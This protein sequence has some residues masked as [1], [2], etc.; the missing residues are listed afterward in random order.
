MSDQFSLF[1]RPGA[2]QVVIALSVIMFTL[3]VTGYGLLW[4]YVEQQQN[5]VGRTY[6]LS[7]VTD[8]NNKL[9]SQRENLA[10]DTF[11]KP[12]IV[13]KATIILFEPTGQTTTISR[14][15][16][17][18]VEQLP[19]WTS[20]SS[21]YGKIFYY[22]NG[23][24]S[25]QNL[26]A[27][28]RLYVR[29]YYYPFCYRFTNPVYLLPL[30]LVFCIFLLAMIYLRKRLNLWYQM[31]DYA[32]DLHLNTHKGYQP[33]ATTLYQHHPELLHLA[34]L[35]NRYAFKL[36]QSHQ[37]ITALRYHHQ[38]LVD[39]AP[40][41]LFM[42]NRK[43]RINYFN[44]HFSQIFQ[45]SFSDN[46]VY[47]L[48][49]FITGLD[50]AAQQ[51]LND[52]ETVHTYQ[53]IAVTNLQCNLY[54]QLKINPHYNRYGRL[55]GYSCGLED[56]TNYQEKLQQAWVEDK[57]TSDKISNFNKMWAV[58]GHELRTPLGGIVGM[59]GLLAD[60][61]SQFNR[62]QQDTID[63]LQHSSQTMM[64]LLNDM[65]NVAKFDVGKLQTNISSM[66]LLRTI[67]QTAELMVGNARRQ[68]ISLYT[69]IHPNVP[70][71]VDC[72]E[73]RLRQI[74]LNLISNAV[75]FTQKGYVA[76]IVTK[77]DQHHPI[78]QQR[79]G[80][81]HP[82]PPDWLKI[83]IQD[84]GIGISEQDQQKLF[85]YFNQANETI[86]QQF[87]GTGLGLAISNRFSHLLGGF[88]H[89]E[90]TP[91]QGSEFQL[92]LPL[93][94]YRIQPVYDYKTH[95]LSVV[96][97]IISPFA[98]FQKLDPVLDYVNLPHHIFTTID[99]HMVDAINQLDFNGLTPV[100]IVDDEV[101][102]VTR[103]LLPQIH[104]FR[105]AIK[106]LYSIESY[107]TLP[108]DLLLEYDSY[109]QKPTSLSNVLAELN[110]LYELKVN[111][112]KTSQNLPAQ[113]AFSQFLQQ[114]PTLGQQQSATHPITLTKNTTASLTN[115]S[116]LGNALPHQKI[117]LLAEDNLV[118]QKIATKHLDHLGYQYLIASDGEQAV[119]L[120]KEHRS[121]IG[122]VLMD[123]RMPVLDGIAAT[124]II[125]LRKDSI[126]IVALTANDTDDD[127]QLCFEAGMDSFLTKPLDKQKLAKI[128]NRYML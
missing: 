17:I 105:H 111:Q 82:L 72:D 128:I 112:T 98:I 81:S 109:L 23:F 36:S 33:I 101:L 95:N 57:Q 9:D 19:N 78:I 54:Y 86:S 53:T 73:G 12:D 51:L 124:R 30:L 118:N 60:D 20:P 76:V 117:I 16:H 79:K 28:Y 107:R 59:I 123:C 84:T 102:A 91:S 45:T 43:G 49:D 92:F 48:S 85:S 29:V 127:K 122:L 58:L 99:Q 41:P 108:A 64:Q 56:V 71:F 24:E 27:G 6:L 35:L 67:R 1:H 15:N 3:V 37:M 7:I 18:T 68:K 110:H 88:I 2:R 97:L 10:E 77:T 50:K 126:P 8:I 119:K 47:M 90:S 21:D 114:H 70:R 34:Q 100:F 62:E 120:L 52:I 65:L 125:R 83:V 104:S 38:T 63:T 44:K 106:I 11:V 115:N 69:F 26:Q 46:V 31:L 103:T 25:W 89:L 42:M 80:L 4:L 87:G 116:R 61:K 39:K 40:M 121:Q 22:A 75:K 94:N 66:D 113:V 93:E 96:L 32:Q 55:Q 5:M 13:K 14:A 74:I